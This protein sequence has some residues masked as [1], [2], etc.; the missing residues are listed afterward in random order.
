VMRV[1]VTW[2]Y[3]SPSGEGSEILEAEE[4]ELEDG[5]LNFYAVEEYPAPFIERW[6]FHPH[7]RTEYILFRSVNK[8]EI[9]EINWLSE[10]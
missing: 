5:W 4:I 10:S 7:P 6:L 2:K 1:G 8:A 3:G 9:S